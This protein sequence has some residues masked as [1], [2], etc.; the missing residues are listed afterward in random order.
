MTKEVLIHMKGLQ[1]LE[2]EQSQEEP[3]ELITVGEYYFRND[4]HYLLFEEMLEGFREPTHN[5]IKIRQ[6]KMEVRK[7]GVV[8]VQMIFERSKKNL[9][10]YKTPFG[11]MEMEI[12]TKIAVAEEEDCLQ[13]RAEYALGM[14][15]NPVADCLMQVRVTPKGDKKGTVFFGE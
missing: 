6:G 8:D 12:A 4:T 7:K 2:G 11:T 13:I 14:N 3:L 10:F 5:M 15:G 9:A 1:T